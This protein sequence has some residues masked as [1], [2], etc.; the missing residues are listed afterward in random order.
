MW[1]GDFRNYQSVEL[2]LAEGLTVVTGPNGEG[3][4]NL[5]EAV[6]Y[7]ATL[8][9][10]R[11]APAEALVRQGCTTATVRGE[12]A[13]AGRELLVEA[14]IG[15]TGRG[16]TALNR[17]P[18]RRSGDLADAFRTT[19]FSPDDLELVKGSPAGRRRYLDDTLVSL[20]P[21][22][23]VLRRDLDRVLRQ[24]TAL[25]RQAAGRG[26]SPEMADT[27][28]VWDD[29]LVVAGEALA[30]ARRQLVAD[31]GPLISEAYTKLSG[32]AA[33]APARP[34]AAVEAWYE[35]P[36]AAAGLAASLEAVRADEVRRGVSLV[37]PHRDDLTLSLGDMPART[38]ASQGEQ[39]CLALALKLASHRLVGAQIGEPPIL[40]LDD[41]FSELDADRSS[42]LLAYLRAAEPG[43]PT[44]GQTLLSSTAKGPPG[45]APDLVVRIAAGE[46]LVA[47][48]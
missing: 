39:R 7:L 26:L 32:G 38:H 41:V 5:L 35:S 29:R 44:A 43:G 23:D 1:L 31:M 6:G 21:R 12:G 2:A 14:E 16:R 17:Q 42:A 28:D 9:S 37:G 22:N 33:L 3:K 45:A 24:R 27:L 19:V 20:H 36:W 46:A 15:M 8:S 10:F 25:L 48:G 11:G 40:L 18:V 47:S 4:T 13:R 30:S 34:A